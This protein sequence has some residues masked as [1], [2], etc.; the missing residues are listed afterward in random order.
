[1]NLKHVWRQVGL[2][3]WCGWHC[4]ACNQCRCDVKE[5]RGLKRNVCPGR[6]TKRPTVQPG[7]VR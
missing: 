1:M 5:L 6:D 3:L 7:T 2:C 4:D